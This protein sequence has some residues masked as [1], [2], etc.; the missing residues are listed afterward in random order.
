[1]NLIYDKNLYFGKLDA[2][3]AGAFP[4][5][6]D[7]GETNADRMTA[8]VLF[9]VSAAAAANTVTVEGSDTEDFAAAAVVGSRTFSVDEVVAGTCPVAISPNKFRY[10]RVKV[11]A[12]A[13]GTAEAFLNTYIG[14]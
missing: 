6:L 9:N 13:T 4:N 2:V 14:K 1:M 5:V 11:S 12:D 7:L 10:L 3:A 8:D